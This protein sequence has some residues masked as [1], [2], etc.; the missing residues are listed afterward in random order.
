MGRRTRAAARDDRVPV[1]AEISG[2]YRAEPGEASGQDFWLVLPMYFTNR[3]ITED[4]TEYRDCFVDFDG[5]I[6]LPYGRPSAESVTHW[7]YLPT[8]P[9]MTV[10]S[11]LGQDAQTALRNALG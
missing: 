5:I 8:L 11:T 4:G 3:H 6:R 9:G 1:A 10:H 7:A 2:G